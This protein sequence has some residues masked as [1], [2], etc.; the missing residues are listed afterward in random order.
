MEDQALVDNVST[1]TDIYIC[2][3]LWHRA[4]VNVYR[5]AF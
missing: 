3:C 2:V 5:F 1:H 4:S